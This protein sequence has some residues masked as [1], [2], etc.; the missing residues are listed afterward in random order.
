[1]EALVLAAK[2]IAAY[3]AGCVALWALSPEP[4]P[5]DPEEDPAMDDPRAKTLIEQIRR[6]NNERS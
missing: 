4:A 6:I 2:V 5:Y 3:V 1:M